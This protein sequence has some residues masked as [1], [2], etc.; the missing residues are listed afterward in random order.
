MPATY[1][2]IATPQTVSGSSTNTITFSSVSSAYT[3][4]VVVMSVGATSG[5][6]TGFGMRFNSDTGTNYSDSR[7]DGDGSSVTSA[8]GTSQSRILQCSFALPETASVYAPVIT[9]IFNYTNTTTFK[10]TLTRS[11]SASTALQALVGT[12]RAT[13]AAISSVTFFTFAGNFSSGSTF[14]LYG[15]KAA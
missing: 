3:D 1:E 6:S 14:A 2:S 5:S 13:P 12:W 7:I 9:Q 11:N 15:I 10:A 4:L 8:R